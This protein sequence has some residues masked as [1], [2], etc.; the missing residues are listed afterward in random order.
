MTTVW[1]LAD[2]DREKVKEFSRALG[3]KPI[4]AQIM[5]ARGIRTLREAE[6]FLNP[7]MITCPSPFLLKGMTECVGRIR[8]AVS[9]GENILIFGDRDVDGITSVSII[10]KTLK[11]LGSKNVFWYIPATEGYGL[12]MDTIERFKKE[13]DINLIITVDC[14]I[15]NAAEVARAKDIGIDTIVTDH[16]EP[17]G[18]LPLSAVAIINPK[19]PDS[20]YPTRD[21]AGCAVAFKVAHALLFSYNPYYNEELVALDIETTGLHP[22]HSE[23]CEIGAVITKNGSIVDTFQTLVKTRK[24]IPP[25][26]S[27]IHGI[28][29]DMCAGAPPIKEAL[30]KLESFVGKRR[31]LIHNAPFDLSFLRH[32]FKME[33]GRALSNDYIDT[34]QMSRL[35]FPFKSHALTSLVSDLKI[36]ISEHHRALAD[37]TAC[38]Y[39]FWR[40]QEM[41]D[42]RI[43]YFLEEHLDLVS[44]G[45]LA[46]IMPLVGENRVLVKRGLELLATTRKVGVREILD[47]A[48]KEKN[49]LTLTSKYVSW[50]ITPLLNAAGRMGKADVA[51]RLLMTTRPEEAHDLYDEVVRLK[52]GRKELQEVNIE[53]FF[54]RLKE[55]CDVEKDAVLVVSADDVE[56]G[57]TGIVASHIVRRLKK[58]A[59]L[60]VVK[61]GIAQGAGRSV[62]GFNILAALEK[63]AQRHSQIL[64]K[65]GGHKSAI[66]LS[67]KSENISDFRRAINE[68]SREEL[69]LLTPEE[70]VVA[71]DACIK[72][73][74]IT[75]DFLKQI[76]Q[77]EPFGPENPP[78]LFWI[79]NLEVKTISRMGADGEHLRVKFSRGKGYGNG[80]GDISAI[81]WGMSGIA[82]DMESWKVVDVAGHI[83][84]HLWQDKEYMQIQIIDVKK[85]EQP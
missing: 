25:E 75:P 71:L 32:S 14:G 81:G 55:Q 26:V 85:G 41:T 27:A 50:N 73:A 10:A 72:A 1:R 56:H 65:Y 16:H 2:I 60:L 43:K 36:N 3:I 6:D 13:H 45:T 78:P 22:R 70:E 37:A 64:I 11:M 21:L 44:V 69:S 31:L 79:K 61:N 76:E 42:A 83:E 53:K 82:D 30:E 7:D 12:N 34:L 46:D 54:L 28:T 58:P 77:L 35:H 48:L 67:L 74:D 47:G 38:A 33:L 57:V 68:I 17:P 4:V 84:S 19:L 40:L 80:V 62:G 5:L 66:G 29:D 24:P 59:I 20:T 23:I 15:S 9:S 49:T 8:K 39:L 63:I 52:I 51:C 18:E